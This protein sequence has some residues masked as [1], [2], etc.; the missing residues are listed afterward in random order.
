MNLSVSKQ[1]PNRRLVEERRYRKKNPWILT[2][3]AIHRRVWLFGVDMQMNVA[4]LR[5]LWDRDN[6]SSLRKPSINRIN[7]DGP[8]SLDNCEYMELGDNIRLARRAKTRVGWTSG[9]REKYNES[10]RLK[11][12]AKS[13]FNR[14]GVSAAPEGRAGELPEVDE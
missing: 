2:Y 13:S 7:P 11:R 12:I 9:R 4:D 10:I 6:A 8:Y 3:K 1:S 14:G 5:Y